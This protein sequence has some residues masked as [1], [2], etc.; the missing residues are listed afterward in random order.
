MGPWDLGRWYRPLALLCVAGCAVLFVIGT[1]P[2]NEQALPIVG[3]TVLL[4]AVAWF[5]GVRQR[6]RGPPPVSGRSL[7]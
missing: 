6:F 5:G 3:G 2:P 1:R 7:S 4:L